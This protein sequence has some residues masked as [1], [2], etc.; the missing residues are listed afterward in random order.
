MGSESAWQLTA[1]NTLYANRYYARDGFDTPW[2]HTLYQ[3]D[4]F[5]DRMVEIYQQDFLPLING[6]LFEYIAACCQRVSAASELDQIRWD[7]G[8]TD[9]HAEAEALQ[10]FMRG[11]TA[12]L[13][14]IWIDEMPYYMVKAD[15]ATG[16]F[17]GYY[18]VSPGEIFTDLPVFENTEGF[19]G[20]YDVHTGEPFD[21]AKPVQKDITIRARWQTQPDLWLGK[22]VKIMPLLVLLL[23]I[24]ILLV[25][26]WKRGNLI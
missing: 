11:R 21:P 17:Y 22:I 19:L 2:F 24:P 20:W 23:I 8:G 13:S 26:D 1:P 5:Y 18:A 15:N 14:S 7:L 6:F 25:A 12:F 16:S 3:K 9:I 4:L 10:S